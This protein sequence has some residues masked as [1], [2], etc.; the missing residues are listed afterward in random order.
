MDFPPVPDVNVNKP[1]FCCLLCFVHTITVGEVT[2]LDHELLDDPVE[3]GS[4]VTEAF[5][6]CAQSTEVLSGLGDRLPVETNHNSAQFL[7][8]MCDI[9]IDLKEAVN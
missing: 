9:E 8:S 3:S 1:F 7:I 2:T 4:L 5:F 6:P